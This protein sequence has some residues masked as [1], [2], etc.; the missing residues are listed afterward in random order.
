MCRNLLT[1][2]RWARDQK[3]TFHSNLPV[4]SLSLWLHYSLYLLQLLILQSYSV[5]HY[6]IA[7]QRKCFLRQYL[8][9]A[10]SG[11][12]L[13]PGGEVPELDVQ[14]FNQLGHGP[15]RGWHVARTQEAF[16]LLSQLPGYNGRRLTW[17]E[18]WAKRGEGG[19][20]RRGQD[21]ERKRE[22]QRG[23]DLDR[24]VGWGNKGRKKLGHEEKVTSSGYMWREG[25]QGGE[26]KRCLIWVN[27]REGQGGQRD[28]LG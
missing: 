22:R 7:S 23:R 17:A 12:V 2:E 15:H 21:K 19:E 14:Q 20:E 25:R 10:P 27:G 4:S 18:L 13:A 16:G 3:R 5:T 28:R 1:H 8:G 9:E 11:T 26:L 24:D 6:V